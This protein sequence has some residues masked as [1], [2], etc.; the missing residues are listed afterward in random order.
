MSGRW[1]WDATTSKFLIDRVAREIF[2]IPP[3]FVLEDF[4]DLMDQT[5]PPRIRGVVWAPLLAGWVVT[6]EPFVKAF[7]IMPFATYDLIW[8]RSTIIFEHSVKPRPSL[9]PKDEGWGKYH[10]TVEVLE[11]DPTKLVDLRSYL[12]TRPNFGGSQKV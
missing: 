5:M 4:D 10:G 6:T 8:I 3:E 2:G 11:V 1:T 12:A 7:Q 9:I